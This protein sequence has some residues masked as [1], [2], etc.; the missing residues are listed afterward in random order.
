MSPVEKYASPFFLPRGSS[1]LIQ[2]LFLESSMSANNSE[3]R[4][5]LCAFAYSD[6][7]HCR[8]LRSSS[9]SKYCLHHER[10]LRHLRQADA[11]AS[12]VAAPLSHDFVSGTSLNYSLTRLFSAIADGRVPPKTAIPLINLSKILLKTIPMANREYLMAF[13]GFHCWDRL[14]RRMYG[15]KEPYPPPPDSP[16]DPSSSKNLADSPTGDPETT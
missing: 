4:A 14:V 7:R 1:P 12:D 16:D 6:G 15:Y 9:K 5:S 10:K 11:T 8:M 2:I 13:R 3:D